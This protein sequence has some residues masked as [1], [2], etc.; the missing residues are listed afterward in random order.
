MSKGC[1]YEIHIKKTF[2]G[3]AITFEWYDGYIDVRKSTIVIEGKSRKRLLEVLKDVIYLNVESYSRS[4]YPLLL[5][6]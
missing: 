2:N 5:K 6:S 1:W 3:Y 4:G